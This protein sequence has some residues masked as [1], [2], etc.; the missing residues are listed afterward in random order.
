MEGRIIYSDVPEGKIFFPKP[1]RKYPKRKNKKKL[2]S[3]I[4][5]KYIIIGN[6]KEK[7][8]D[9]ENITINEINNDFLSLISSLEEEQCFD[10]LNNILS[11][12]VESDTSS[13]IKNKNS[14]K[15][16]RAK[17]KTLNELIFSI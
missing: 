3:H 17:N 9:L 13:Y 4:N 6:K 8:Y 10:E 16:R 1:I 12:S 5:D 15:V 7:P 11:N 14:N 2:K